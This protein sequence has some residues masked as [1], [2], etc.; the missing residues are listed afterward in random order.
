[1]AIDL[2]QLVA[3]TEHLASFP[4]IVHQINHAVDD[5]RSSLDDI[6]LI[7]QE[8]PG[9]TARLLKIANSSFYNCPFP[10]DTIPRALT[11]IG[12]KQ[13]KDLVA[14]TFAIRVF[15]DMSKS[16]VDMHSFWRHSIACGSAARSIAT[17]RREVNV[18]KYYLIGLL[19]DVGRLVLYQRFPDVIRKIILFCKEKDMLLYEAERKALGFDHAM[20]G[21]RLLAKWKLPPE[22][23]VPV[24]NHHAP[25][26]TE[27]YFLET[28]IVHVADIMAQT[29]R[30]GTSGERFIPP[31]FNEAWEKINLPTSVVP[32]ILQQ[33]ESQ[34]ADAVRVFLGES[35]S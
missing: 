11:M 21:G 19:H 25:V 17:L 4:A 32:Q 3:S 31:P 33:T 20:L 5:P 7:I 16:G 30:H 12:T 34:Y 6:G 27:D 9:L 13:L 26:P 18:E 10:I 23:H 24:G 28:S 1:M 15:G 8:D 14:A 22:L 35:G 29:L 2:D